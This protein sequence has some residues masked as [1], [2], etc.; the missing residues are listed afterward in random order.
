MTI[1]STTNRVS[2][3][4]NGVT[5]AFPFNLKFFSQADLKV[6]ET[7]KATGIDTVKS[8]TTDYTISGTADASGVYQDGGTINAVT[9]PPNTV[10]WTIYRDPAL[11][12]TV[13]H[14]DNDPIPAASI[15]NP[16]DK[17]TVAEQRTRELVTRGL[18]Q[19]DGDTTDIGVLP[20][21]VTRASKY[22]AFDAD[23]NPIAAAD[24]GAYPASAFMGG[25]L[26]AADA[27]DA[28]TALG[29]QA[30]DADLDAI[31]A[32]T[33]SAGRV[34][35]SD[36]AAWSSYD[37]L[38]GRNRIINPDGRVYQRAVAAVADDTYF[39]DRWYAL[40]QTGTVTPSA[41]TDPEDGYPAGV[42]I[43]QSQASAQ[44]FG[45]AQIIEA[46]NCKDLRGKSGVFVPRIRAS[47]AQ[48][49]RY[50]ILGW[51]GT[52]DSVTSDV[53]N[54]WTSSTYTAGN[55]F[56]AA[57]VS[58]LAVGSQTPAA[59]TW[60]SLTALSGALGSTFNNIVVLVWTEGTAAQNF[61]LDFD[62]NQFEAGA[63]PTAFERRPFGIELSLCQRY[64]AKT[65][66][67]GTAPAQNAGLTGA[68]GSDFAYSNAAGCIGVWTLPVVM[69][70]APTVTTYNPGAAAST[71][72]DQG[73][74][75]NASVSVGT[76]S[77]REVRLQADTTTVA[78]TSYRIH[79]TADAEL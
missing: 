40:S 51:T 76:P 43:T 69:R 5:T 57:N 62:F 20:A 14:V 16:L 73:N 2:Y 10:R 12:Q 9:A 7:V 78:G 45:Y 75:A 37:Y 63:L 29:A 4:G 41:L 22:L 31:A 23:G 59:N 24:P 68:A 71:W 48:A 15:D 67:Q 21:K 3:N 19:P 17:L 79:A 65:F 39:A 6:I 47:A 28:R 11:T 35:M 55:F 26:G 72:R 49:I 34:V 32:I 50:A 44:R 13:E 61:T 52:E 77:D 60:T 46:K 38:V 33:H 1:S 56:P 18:R 74:T 8:L 54:D 53:V 66:P 42:R 25:V 27:A 58:V 36:G 70:A 64:Y 30:Q